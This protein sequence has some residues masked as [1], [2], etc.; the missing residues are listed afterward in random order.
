MSD[1][2]KLCPMCGSK[3]IIRYP[4]NLTTTPSYWAECMKLVCGLRTRKWATV[5]EATKAWNR[6]VGEDSLRGLLAEAMEAIGRTPIK[7]DLDLMAKI[8][9]EFVEK[10]KGIE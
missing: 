8:E 10:E 1:E 9:N 5:A 4:H 2:L 6:R 7:A 3:A